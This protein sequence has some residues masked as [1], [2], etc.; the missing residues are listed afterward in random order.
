MSEFK[1]KRIAWI[2]KADYAGRVRKVGEGK[3]SRS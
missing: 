2:H 1:E 3:N